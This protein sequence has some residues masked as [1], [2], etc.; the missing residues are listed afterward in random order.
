[1]TSLRGGR[2]L[3][4]SSSPSGVTGRFGPRP[5]HPADHALSLADLTRLIHILDTEHPWDVHSIDS[6]HSE[7]ITCLEWDQSGDRGSG[8]PLGRGRPRRWP[9]V[10]GRLFPSHGPRA[11]TRTSSLW[12]CGQC[13]LFP[14]PEPPL[15]RAVCRCPAPAPLGRPLPGPSRAAGGWPC[16]CAVCDAGVSPQAPGSCQRMPTDR[17][18][19]GAWRTTWPTAGRAPWAAWWRGTPSSPCPGC[20]TV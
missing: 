15:R 18:S 10:P 17:S 3:P 7:A 11:G 6:E 5:G 8:V 4:S 16:P 13:F 9:R 1:M 14:R 19:A 2:P 20:T 12:L